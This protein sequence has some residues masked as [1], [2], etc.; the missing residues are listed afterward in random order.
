MRQIAIAASVLI[1]VAMIAGLACC[2]PMVME[3]YFTKLEEDT[4][5]QKN[6]QTRKTFKATNE[7]LIREGLLSAN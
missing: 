7:R 6:E 1:A 2:A 5:I 4:A 3:H